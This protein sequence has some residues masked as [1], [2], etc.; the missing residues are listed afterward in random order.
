LI[1]TELQDDITEDHEMNGDANDEPKLC[2]SSIA[3]TALPIISHPSETDLS[4]HQSNP[5]MPSGQGDLAISDLP[6]Q[7]ITMSRIKEGGMLTADVTTL[8][9]SD[10]KPLDVNTIS[11]LPPSNAPQISKRTKSS[12]SIASQ[13]D[14][15]T[16]N[17][18]A[19][20]S[21]VSHNVQ[22]EAVISVNQAAVS[23][24]Q[25]IDDQKLAD[26]VKKLSEELQNLK[27]TLKESDD[28]FKTLERRYASKS[29][30]LELSQT[31]VAEM[32]KLNEKQQEDYKL[33]QAETESLKEQLKFR[34]HKAQLDKQKDLDIINY[35]K[36][37]ISKLAGVINELQLKKVEVE[38]GFVLEGEEDSPNA[39]L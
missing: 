12:V 18:S 22:T 26:Q 9:T 8:P 11:D 3:D 25:N 13:S 1:W 33:V 31:K 35:K 28:A 27:A 38:Q 37:E 32:W 29:K 6:I 21:T 30:E 20:G 16:P 19:R 10:K 24:Q 17:A 4:E 15:F 36:A 7:D 14:Y 34:A 23:N 5:T 2:I 39:K